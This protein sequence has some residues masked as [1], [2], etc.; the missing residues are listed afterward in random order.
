MN[1]GIR[2]PCAEYSNGLSG[3]ARKRFFEH[4]LYGALAGLTLPAGEL[5]PIVL[6]NELDRAV[7]HR[8]Q[9]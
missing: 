1:A 3:Q 2:P 8:P 7:G 4:S 6:Q 9:N 5:A